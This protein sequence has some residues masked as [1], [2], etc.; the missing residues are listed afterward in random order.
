MYLK[1]LAVIDMISSLLE[2]MK[3]FTSLTDQ[4][5]MSTKKVSGIRAVSPGRAA[6]RG[7]DCRGEEK[8]TKG[9]DE[10]KPGGNHEKVD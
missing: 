2:V 3:L 1:T 9:T 10:I 4:L 5:S 7:G 8:R 6:E